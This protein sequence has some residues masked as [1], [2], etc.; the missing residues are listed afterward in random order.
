MSRKLPKV[1]SDDERERFKDQ[2]NAPRYLTPHRNLVMSRLMLECGLRVGEVVALERDHVDLNTGKLTVREGKG[3]KD[4]TLWM[5]DGLRSALAEWWERRIE[6]LPG[7]DLLFVTSSGKPVQTG[8][9][10][11]MVKRMARKAD[12]AEAERVSPH[13][14]RHTFATN[15]LR[16][17]ANLRTVQDALGHEDVST[18]MRYTHLVNGEV[19]SVMKQLAS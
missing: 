13:T 7:D 12:V 11:R 1:L 15:L 16:E 17:G 6:E 2:F 5:N 3:S 8:Y 14:L 4:R 10:R 19:E 9:L 18:T